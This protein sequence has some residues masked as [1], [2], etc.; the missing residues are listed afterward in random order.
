[1]LY[2]THDQEEAFYLAD[3]VL[4]MNDGAI[5]EAGSPTDLYERPETPFTRQFVGVRNHFSGRI[6]RS[7]DGERVV[8]S[9]LVDFR[10]GNADYISNGTDTGPVRCF[11]RPEDIEL[12][13][14]GS[15]ADG[16]IEL[17]GTVVAEG[18]LGDSYEVTVRFGG[19]DTELVV[20][21]ETYQQFDRGD[22]VSIQFQPRRLQ[23][24]GV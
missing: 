3:R 13:Q 15:S 7:A 22:E 4:V 16:R 10:L 21:T 11:L 2:V 23:V 1:M 24:Y 20:H 14:F 19:A 18:I 5:V 8:R 6:E 12:G 9:E 17:T